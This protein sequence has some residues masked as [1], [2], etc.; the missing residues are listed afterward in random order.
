MEFVN[1]KPIIYVLSG[2]A[3]TGKNV[4]A[5]LIKEIYGEL[6]KKSINLS[7]ASYLKEYAKNILSWDGSEETKPREFLQQL[8]VD[9]IKKT[10]D[11]RFVINR[12]LQDIKIYSYFYD[13][14]TISDARFIEEIEDVKNSFS[15][16]ISIRITK[17]T[18]STLTEAEKKHI[19]ET[20]LDNYHNYDYVVSND[21]SLEEL[22]DRLIIIIE[23]VNNGN[24]N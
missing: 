4:A 3:H 7:Y 8:G 6:N 21:G 11:S 23:E 5:N 20:A 14:I 12:L 17:K 9:L 18:D 10:I 19:S 1:K 15:K 16:V 24:R 2:K 13:V 22:K